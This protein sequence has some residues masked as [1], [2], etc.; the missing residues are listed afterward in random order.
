[1]KLEDHRGERSG[2]PAVSK[3]SLIPNS[4]GVRPSFQV[5]YPPEMHHRNGH[6]LPEPEALTDSTQQ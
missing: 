6:R 2:A 5:Q 3:L 1:M 4:Q